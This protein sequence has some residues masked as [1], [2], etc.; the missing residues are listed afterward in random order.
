MFL[1][2][3]T[4]LHHKMFGLTVIYIPKEGIGMTPEA[5]SKDKDLVKRL[6]GIVVYWT[7]QIRIGLQDQDQ[8]A[9]QELLCPND[10]YEFWKYR[11]TCNNIIS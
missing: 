9:P 2:K 1:A 4:D 11:C 7:R 5:A 3:L 8:N 10:E 6:E